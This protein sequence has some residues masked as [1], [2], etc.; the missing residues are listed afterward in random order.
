[1]TKNMASGFLGWMSQG[2]LGIKAALRVSGLGSL[3]GFGLGLILIGIVPRQGG[4]ERRA[5][6]GLGLELELGLGLKLG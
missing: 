1:M 6:I 2:L 4:L 5:R 3:S